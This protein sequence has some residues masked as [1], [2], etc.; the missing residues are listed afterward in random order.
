MSLRKKIT[1]RSARLGIMGLGYVGL[2]LAVEF[3]KAGF[4]TVGIDIDAC[5]VDQIRAG[6]SYIQDV[7]EQEVSQLVSAGKLT[8]TTDPSV[9]R[10]LDAVSICVPTP[11]RKTRDPD[12][13]Y[14]VDSTAKIRQH[15]HPGML[16]TLES[17]TYPGTGYHP[18]AAAGRGHGLL[19]GSLRAQV[20]AGGQGA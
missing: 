7:P 18:A 8:A 11:L 2:P 1:D 6:T 9:L 16:I 13:Q 12:I 5:R 20:E 15:L 17:T 3:G 19:F 4:T 14:T 10:R